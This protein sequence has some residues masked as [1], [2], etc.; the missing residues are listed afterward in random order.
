MEYANELKDNN[1]TILPMRNTFKLRLLS[2]VNL[3]D[4]N[5]QKSVALFLDIVNYPVIAFTQI[6]MRYGYLS[7]KDFVSTLTIRLV[8]LFGI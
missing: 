1:R 2:K 4:S 8:L 7:N 5:K 6:E 3:T